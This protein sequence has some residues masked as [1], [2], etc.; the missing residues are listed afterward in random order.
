[1]SGGHELVSNN[2]NGEL[3]GRSASG[4]R[5]EWPSNVDG[6]KKKCASGYNSRFCITTR[7]MLKESAT[8]VGDAVHGAAV[9]PLQALS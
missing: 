7:G 2:D 6:S 1:V 8:V 4:R 9:V 3:F 5:D